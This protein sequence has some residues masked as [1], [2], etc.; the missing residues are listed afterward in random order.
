MSPDCNDINNAPR[1]GISEDTKQIQRGARSDV[2]ENLLALHAAATPSAMRS[3]H[4]FYTILCFWFTEQ[5]SN[6]KQPGAQETVSG[7]ECGKVA[8]DIQSDENAILLDRRMFGQAIVFGGELS[9]DRSGAAVDC[10]A[11]HILLELWFSYSDDIRYRA[12]ELFL[13]LK[14]K[15]RRFVA[16]TMRAPVNILTQRCIRRKPNRG[17]D[18]VHGIGYLR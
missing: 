17:D 7:P 11:L 14:S 2:F 12:V 6:I 4:R 13:I 9:S 8:E 5:K 3:V 16:V 10:S 15:A 1:D 18:E